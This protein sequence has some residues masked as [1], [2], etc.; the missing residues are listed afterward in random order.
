MA[1]VVDDEQGGLALRPLLGDVASLASVDL[2]P[3]VGPQAQAL[4][5]QLAKY[6]EMLAAA[7]K[8][9]KASTPAKA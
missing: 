7:A 6:P 8:D 2:S 9:A 1:G 5:L 3:L 4:M